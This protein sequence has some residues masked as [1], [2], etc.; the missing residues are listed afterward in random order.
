M[1]NSSDD[2]WLQQKIPFLLGSLLAALIVTVAVM[3]AVPPVSRD[4][5]VHH[6]A[7]PKLYLQNG[8]I[9]EI[10]SIKY[11]Y[12]PMNLELLYLIP[13]YF[14]NDILPKFIHFGF[15]LMTGG[16]I[17]NYLNRRLNRNYALFGV[18]SFLSL[19]VIV[20]LSITAYVDLGLVFFSMASL[21]LIFKWINEH[22]KISYLLGGAVC[23]G[24]ALGTKY[25]GLLVFFLLALFVPYAYARMNSG[26]K[27]AAGRAI[28]YGTV[29]V[30]VAL[31]IF[32]PWMIRNYMWT[33][34]PL[35]P[36]YDSI[37]NP[38]SPYPSAPLGHFAVR[39]LVYNESWLQIALIPLRIF[40][41][42]QDA[43]PQYF[44]GQLNPFLLLL[45][46]LAFWR[47][48]SDQPTQVLER[49]LLCGFAILYI[50]YA[51]F[52]KDMR[53]RYIAPLL[54][55]LVLLA[56]FGLHN[57]YGLV[58]GHVSRNT[59]SVLTVMIHGAMVV[60][61]ILNGQ[62]IYKQFRHVAPLGY[63]SGQV[64][65][66]AYIQKYRPEYPVFKYIN[67]H[68]D[69]KARLLAVFMGRRNYYTDREM[70][71][72]IELLK[73]IVKTAHSVQELWGAVGQHGFTHLIMERRLYE[74][75]QKET[76]TAQERAQ[77][78]DFWRKHAALIYRHGS[79]ELYRLRHDSDP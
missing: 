33:E 65:R 45:P 13:L 26:V 39:H 36:L 12:Y 31:I 76:F 11:S 25:N 38:E 21:M 37:F 22:F 41:Q 16:L 51:F 60:M 74:K 24:L 32:A 57:L 59:R 7:V 69:P 52:T 30:V 28:T 2:S 5:L 40:F 78:S 15:A 6:L 43:N 8:G 71:F 19:P 35:F 66:D 4:A 77:L 61:I 29:F 42:G 49:Q 62:Y 64:D 75:W 73:D 55:A 79:Y 3:A 58:A 20:K 1:S 70:I 68:L 46:L 67:A 27:G 50:L 23:C 10:P 72:G 53:I 48:P 9:Y 56:M 63:L 47:Q 44:D 54:P 18:I 17:F 34:N 14:K